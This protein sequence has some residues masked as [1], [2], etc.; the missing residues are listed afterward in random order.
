[1]NTTNRTSTGTYEFTAPNGDTLTA[2]SVTE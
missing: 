1:V 2:R